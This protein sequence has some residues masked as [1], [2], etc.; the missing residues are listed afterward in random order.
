VLYIFCEFCL[1]F[2]HTHA[3]IQS[4]IAAQLAGAL[5][6]IAFLWLRNYFANF[7]VLTGCCSIHSHREQEQ[8]NAEDV[9]FD[10]FASEETGLISMGKFLAGLKTTGIRR[11]DPRVRELMDNLKKV[12]K[13]N[14]YETGSSAETQHLNRETFKA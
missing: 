8:R 7:S 6:P 13:L 2:P 12:H 1:A 11:N 10:M 14:N 5:N 4:G 9:L 3:K